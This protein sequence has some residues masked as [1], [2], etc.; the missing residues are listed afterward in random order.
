MPQGYFIVPGP[1]AFA[2]VLFNGKGEEVQRA[3]GTLDHATNNVAE[4]RAVIAGLRFAGQSQVNKI[5][6]LTDSQLLA[7]QIQGHYRVKNRALQRL[8]L[9][10]QKLRSKFSTFEISFLP[11]E[12]NQLTDL[13]VRNC[14]KNRRKN[15]GSPSEEPEGK[16]A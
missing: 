13:L 2:Y 12:E 1:G 4:Y 7:K 8:S 16:S 10:V 3:A 5:H 9:E 15:A 6:V 14:L 11:R